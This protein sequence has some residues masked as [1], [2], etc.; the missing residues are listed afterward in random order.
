MEAM[1]S[2][3]LS[4]ASQR[5]RKDSDV[6]QSESKGLRTL[7]T[8]DEHSS[9]DLKATRIRSSEG[10]NQIRVPAHRVRQKV[11]IVS[12]LYLLVHLGPQ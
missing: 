10:R 11:P 2:Q 3:D 1:M 7:G 8:S 12:Y 5:L 6:A 9:P 4:S